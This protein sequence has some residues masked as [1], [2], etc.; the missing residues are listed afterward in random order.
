M[1]YI[2]VLLKSFPSQNN[3]CYREESTPIQPLEGAG[4]K[5]F[6]SFMRVLHFFLMLLISMDLVA[7]ACCEGRHA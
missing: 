3:F 7:L 2:S 6:I 5:S 1:T 4:K